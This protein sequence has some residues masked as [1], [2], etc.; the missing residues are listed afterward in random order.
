MFQLPNQFVIIETPPAKLLGLR[1]FFHYIFFLLFREDICS[2]FLSH[3]HNSK[4]LVVL[5]VFEKDE[6]Q[7]LV[8]FTRSPYFNNSY[9]SERYLSLLEYLIAQ[10]SL[11]EKTTGLTKEKAYPAVFP[12]EAYKKGKLEKVMSGLLSLIFEF[13]AVDY[14]SDY[15]LKELRIASFFRKREKGKLF[16]SFTQKARKTLEKKKKDLKYFQEKLE[17]EE[18]I[19]TFYEVHNTR[20]D[21]LNITTT[22]ENLDIFFILKRLIYTV[23]FLAQNRHIKLDV[24]PAVKLIDLIEP[25]ILEE[26]YFQVP[27]LQVYLKAYQVLKFRDKVR[28]PYYKEFK[29]ALE[30]H[31]EHF[32][33]MELKSL[34]TILRIIA[35]AQYN[36]VEKSEIKELFQLFRD[37]LNKGYLYYDGKIYPSTLNTITIIGSRCNEFNWVENFLIKHRKK[38]TGSQNTEEVYRLNTAYFHFYKEE[39]DEAL[40]YLDET[41]QDLYYKIFAKKLEIMIYFMTDSPL[42]ESRMEAFKILVFRHSKSKMPGDKADIFNRF[43]DILRQIIH[44]KTFKNA[45]R[46]SKILEKV[47]VNTQITERE[48]LMD[49]LKKRLEKLS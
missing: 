31:K 29:D 24:T 16:W 19:E 25:L 45:K 18:E 8:D 26:E 1:S 11:T 13:I 32:P 30:K 41:Y 39:Y 47:K 43:I 4:L 46:L 9:N 5:S 7:R 15:L 36:Y 34:Q 6:L 21:E 2:K 38:I 22:L 28:N 37:H 20:S 14:P 12:N 33:P 44:P 35:T 48:W 27:T 10:P 42:L 23:S 17:L 49:I 3:M 40:N